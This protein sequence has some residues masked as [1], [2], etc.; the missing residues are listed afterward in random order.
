MIQL[1]NRRGAVAF[2][3]GGKA[4]TLRLSVNA[5]IKYE[6]HSGEVI[7]AAFAELQKPGVTDFVRFRSLF[8][9]AVSGDLSLEDAGELMSDLGLEKAIEILSEAGALAFP[10]E[11]SNDD[12]AGNAAAGGKP[13][14]K[15]QAPKV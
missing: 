2:E 14:E 11:S 7:A 5:I 8:W 1:N 10:E 9:A 13:R 3:A 6:E 4:Y 12:D 15:A